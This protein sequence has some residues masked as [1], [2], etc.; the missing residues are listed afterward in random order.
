MQNHIKNLIQIIRTGMPAEVKVAQKQVKKFWHDVYIPQREIGRQAFRVFL[1][2]IKTF[3]QIKDAD[4]QAYFINTLKWPLYAI[5]YENFDVFARF[6]LRYIQH[7]SGKVRQ[8][9]IRAVD[10]LIFDLTLDM[11][12]NY[13]HKGK[14]KEALKKIIARDRMRF[15]LFVITTE[16][17]EEEYYEPKFKRYK[18]ISSLPAG[19]YKS[20]QILM[21]EELLRSEYYET[22]Y[23]EYKNERSKRIL[24]QIKMKYTTLGVDTISDGFMCH[25]CKKPKKRLGS[26]NMNLKKPEMVCEDCAIDQYQKYY[27]YKTR[28]AAAARRR[29]IFDTGYLF[30]DIIVDRYLFENN[31]FLIEELSA[32]EMRKIF[33]FGKDMY[34]QLFRMEDKIRLEE[35]YKQKDI[36]KEIRKT[37]D[38]I[39]FDWKLFN[40]LEL[41]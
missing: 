28:E 16:R 40:S 5:G 20:L 22:V 41:L 29:R 15:G 34:N 39:E 18:Y 26:A 19:V 13:Q 8:A 23:A 33:A 31:K 1:D 9:I 14:S 2:E 12:R 7:P 6:F 11:N 37:L 21:M 17:L 35:T 30:Q 3:E 10:Y 24:P 36:E 25:I 27:D 32:K 38:E 4:H